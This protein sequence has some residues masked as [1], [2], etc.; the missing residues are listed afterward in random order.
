[1]SKLTEADDFNFIRRSAKISD[2]RTAATTR[3]DLFGIEGYTAPVRDH[4]RPKVRHFTSN[5]EK[6]KCFTDL[7]SKLY[8]SNPGPAHKTYEIGWDWRKT[9]AWRTGAFDKH[10]G[11]FL[12]K[13]RQTFTEETMAISKKLPAP[14]KYLPE[15]YGHSKV[16]T[17]G[18][19]K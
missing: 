2:L 16:R 12:K 4:F 15:N 14:N 18:N 17:L 10:T 8:T 11:N 1:V 6:K 13:P 7:H 5:K 3:N 19:Y 9:S